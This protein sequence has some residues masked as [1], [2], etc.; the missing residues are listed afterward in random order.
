M[1]TGTRRPGAFAD[2]KLRR[3]LRGVLP[4][5]YRLEDDYIITTLPLPPFRL[6]LP[7]PTLELL[8]RFKQF[9]THLGLSSPLQNSRVNAGRK[10]TCG[11]FRRGTSAENEAFAHESSR[12]QSCSGSGRFSP[13]YQGSQHELRQRD[14]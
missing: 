6:V 11:G 13:V 1:R 10:A 14:I 5:K 9:L 12:H 8:K 4:T 7:E 3:L 2:C